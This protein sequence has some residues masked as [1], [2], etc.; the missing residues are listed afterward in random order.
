MTLKDIE[1]RV[2]LV[3]RGVMCRG[4]GGEGEEGDIYTSHHWPYASWHHC[5]THRVRVW[6]PNHRISRG[7]GGQ[8]VNPAGGET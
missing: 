4:K 1:V 3:L 5:P 6:R 7:G 2:R 8:S